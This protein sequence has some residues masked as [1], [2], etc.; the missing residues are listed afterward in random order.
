MNIKKIVIPVAGIGVLLTGILLKRNS[1]SGVTN[2][3]SKIITEPQ[4][5]L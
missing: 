1:V 3:A 2:V 4:E 5:N